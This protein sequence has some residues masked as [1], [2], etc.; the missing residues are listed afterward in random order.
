MS[1]TDLDPVRGKG[2][3]RKGFI[4]YE[5]IFVFVILFSLAT[6][7]GFTPIFFISG[8]GPTVIRQIVLQDALIFF[9]LS[10]ILLIVTHVRKRSDFFFWN[11]ISFAL[12][13]IGLLAV[14]FQPSVGSLMGWA[15]RSAQ[16]FGCVFAL[17]AV[18]IARLLATKK[19]IPIEEIIANFFSEAETNYKSL[20]ETSIDAIV[21]F[22]EDY[23]ILLWNKAAER[24]FG[25]TR[26]E[27][28]GISFSELVDTEE[29][30]KFMKSDDESPL[31]N[32]TDLHHSIPIEIIGKSTGKSHFP[33]EMSI[34]QRQQKGKMIYTC[35]LHD[36]SERKQAEK[37]T[38]YNRYH[39]EL[40]EVSIDP[41]VTIN[42]DGIITDVNTATTKV[43]GR[44]REDLIGTDF[45]DYFSDPLNARAGYLSVFKMG[46]IRDYPLEI[47]HIDGH[48]TP[49]LYNASLYLDKEDKVAGIFAI[50]RDVSERI[51][52]EEELK[53]S[54]RYNRSLIEAS[55]D[56]FATISPEGI[57]T[58]VNTAT[59]EVTGYSRD[60]LIGTDFSEYFNEPEKAH[61]GYISAFNNEKVRDYPLNILHKDGHSTPVLLNFSVYLNKKE[62]VLGLFA[63]ARDISQ[64]KIA[65]ESIRE[66][67]QK[68][69]LLTGLTRHDIFN[70][71]S[72]VQG[73]HELAF[74]RSD[75]VKIQEYISRAQMTIEQIE[76]TIG[77]TREYENFGIISSGWIRIYQLIESAKSDL[78]L[79]NI[80]VENQVQMELEVFAD[81]IIRKVFTTLI[82]NAI[83]H[84]G[85]IRTIRFSCFEQN[86]SMFILC[87]DDGV[88]I[89]TD[90]KEYIF[91]HGYGKHT[92]IGLFLS[93]EILS[94]TG[95]S[96]RE[97][98][99]P[100]EGARFEILVPEGKYRRT[101]ITEISEGA[102]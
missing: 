25:C 69:R 14:L 13:S 12:I 82:E 37:I 77:F 26:D 42:P 34:S 100:G 2:F 16:Y 38:E 56:P 27:A 90:E 52:A 22:D 81:P 40:I 91:D 43:T 41:F 68:I 4:L 17:Y 54:L 71:I 33:V 44:R 28:I 58:D 101:I 92:G 36:V 76:K 21:T 72:V 35:I 65:E 94:I 102:I 88:G 84:G 75:P 62:V 7:Q 70:Q 67:N 66:S 10:S 29:F 18:L 78:S 60:V 96:I 86:Y 61:T 47:L 59:E 57:I 9:A 6:I 15:G 85:S 97:C 51:Q 20:V 80:V 53:E 24:M 50:A 89:Q 23:H 73:L 19:G 1:L 31:T 87:E 5:G 93:R 30:S 8:T 79:G 64:V 46:Q 45:C 55:I 11:S 74:Q 63:A 49:V 32:N 48:I 83:R 99:I 95:L 39:R 3:F 98:G